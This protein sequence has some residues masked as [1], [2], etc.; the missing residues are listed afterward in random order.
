M[1]SLTATPLTSMVTTP[2]TTHPHLNGESGR[3]VFG[4][5]ALVEF[6]SVASHHAVSG[7]P[8]RRGVLLS[9]GGR[10]GGGG[11]LSEG[12]TWDKG[13]HGLVAQEEP[14]GTYTYM[15]SHVLT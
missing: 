13:Q 4:T 2:L 12:D 9:R 3:L 7:V 10:L 15:W 6:D 14:V 11:V 1:V 8:P 5:D